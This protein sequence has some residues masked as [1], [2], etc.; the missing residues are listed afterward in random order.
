MHIPNICWQPTCC[1]AHWIL[2]SEPSKP[3]PF[4]SWR[5]PQVYC[6]DFY[7]AAR[8]LRA[9]PRNEVEPPPVLWMSSTGN[10]KTKDPAMWWSLT[11]AGAIYC[12]ILL[13]T[14]EQNSFQVHL[15]L[16]EVSGRKQLTKGWDKPTFPLQSKGDLGSSPPECFLSTTYLWK[17]ECKRMPRTSASSC[18]ENTTE[19]AVESCSREPGQEGRAAHEPP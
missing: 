10:S 4:S 8:T 16:L 14:Q 3:S 11:G 19:R 2:L 13:G 15:L 6:Y 5:K 7:K 17:A 1:V 18:Y 12:P 9:Q